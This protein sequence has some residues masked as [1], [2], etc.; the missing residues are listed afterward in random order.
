MP[1]ECQAK[2]KS[3][4]KSYKDKFSP[5]LLHCVSEYPCSDYSLN[6]KAM[7]LMKEKFPSNE[8]GF[9]DHSIGNTAAIIC[10]S[11]GYQFFEKHFTLNK[12]DNGPD[13]SASADVSEMKSYVREIRRIDKMLGKKIKNIQDEEVGMSLRSKKGIKALV[14]IKKGDAITLDN[15]YAIRPAEYGIC[16]DDLYEVLSKKAIVDIKK[17]TFLER[18]FLI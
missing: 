14:N 6:L 11:K 4:L 15:T 7:D 3:T 17:D 1:L 5:K 2:I 18:K 10:A 8:I 16:V 9:S 13:H 12:N